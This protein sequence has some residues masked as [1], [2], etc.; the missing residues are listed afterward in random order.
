MVVYGEIH[1]GL[2]QHSH[3]L[4]IRGTTELLSIAPG[5]RVRVSARPLAYAQS[6]E[7]LTG[8]DCRLPMRGR[9]TRAVGTAIGRAVSVGGRIVLGSGFTEI[10]PGGR[11]F[12]QPWSHYL[13][14]PGVLETI[15]KAELS[16]MVTDVGVELPAVKALNLAAVNQ[17][18]LDLL[19]RHDRLDHRAPFRA[20]PTRLRWIAYAP[21]EFGPAAQA[22]AAVSLTIKDSPQRVM[23][24]RTTETSPR[25]LA[26]LFEDIAVHDWLLTTLSEL[27]DRTGIGSPDRTRGEVTARL[28]PVIDHLL[29][30]WM[31]S[32]RIAATLRGVWPALEKN[33]G[34][35]RQWDN[36]VQRVR[37]QF[38]VAAAA[39]LHCRFKDSEDPRGQNQRPQIPLE[40]PVDDQDRCV[41]G[42]RSPDLFHHR[43]AALR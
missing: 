6:P 2:I 4:S 29:P 26:T 24:L 19:R 33:P 16:R 25:A 34:F 7:F 18:T 17:R 39:E 31:P 41:A 28:R 37:D 43:A 1:T 10:R 32:V 15:G 36:L 42:H 20:G 38:T 5:E 23:V 40:P 13:S 21:G 8:L 35:T 9:T 11:D 30:L 22:P 3:A 27:L 14:R 12:R